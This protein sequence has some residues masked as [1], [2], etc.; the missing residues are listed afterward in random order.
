L[1]GGIVG[2]PLG[3]DSFDIELCNLKAD[4]GLSDRGGEERA[5]GLR[6]GHGDTR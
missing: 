3:G 2:A 6:I 4:V 5:I 1:L